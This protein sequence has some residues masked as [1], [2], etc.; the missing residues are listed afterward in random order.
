MQLLIPS[1]AFVISGIRGFTHGDTQPLTLPRTEH[2]FW[3]ESDKFPYFGAM[4]ACF[5]NKTTACTSVISQDLL[6]VQENLW[7][8]TR[9]C[10]C[11]K[12]AICRVVHRYTPIEIAQ[13]AGSNTFHIF[14]LVVLLVCTLLV[15]AVTRSVVTAAELFS[16]QQGGWIKGEEYAQI[17]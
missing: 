8:C 1:A 16:K 5:L 2:W 13:E 12:T 15:F 9:V 3:A 17:N 14:T 7:L 4:F 11:L 10:D 6:L